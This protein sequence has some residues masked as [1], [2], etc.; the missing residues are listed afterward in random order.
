MGVQYPR[1]LIARHALGGRNDCD[2]RLGN[3][4]RECATDN[5]DDDGARSFDLGVSTPP[6]TSRRFP[7][8]W[9]VEEQPA[10]LCRPR[11]QRTGQRRRPFKVNSERSLP[12]KVAY[13]RAHNLWSR[14][15]YSHARLLRARGP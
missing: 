2:G 1:A 7:P 9:S 12:I 14:R 13:G 10:L 3:F 5:R 15:R 11:P 4:P 6:M 8:P